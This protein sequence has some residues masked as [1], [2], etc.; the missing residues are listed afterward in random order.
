M[1]RTAPAVRTH[2]RVL[3]MRHLR[4]ALRRD[5][6]PRVAVETPIVSPPRQMILKGRAV[7]LKTREAMYRMIIV[8]SAYLE[9]NPQSGQEN[10]DAV[11]C[12]LA[13]LDRTGPRRMGLG[14]PGKA[15]KQKRGRVR[16]P[17]R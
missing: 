17:T 6:V 9:Q 8:A 2:V 5:L 15:A 11:R 13:W 12:V 14:L 16:G 10:L 1:E 7:D 3:A 4:A